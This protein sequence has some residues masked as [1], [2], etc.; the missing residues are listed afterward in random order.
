MISSQK[1]QPDW[2]LSPD[3]YRIG[4]GS[5][6]ASVPAFRA[7]WVQCA[8]EAVLKSNGSLDGLFLDATPK[9]VKAGGT[10]D[11][12]KFWGPMVD[13]IRSKVSFSP[14]LL[15]VSAYPLGAHTGK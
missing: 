14:T 6:S 13:D 9:V 12:I 7:W 11:W 15:N 1:V 5:Y 8:V 4:H 10:E 2:L 3:P